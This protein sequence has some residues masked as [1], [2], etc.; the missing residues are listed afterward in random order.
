[1]QFFYLFSF[2]VA[3]SY[4]VALP[5]PAGLSEKYSSNVD[6][7][8]ASGLEARSYQPG[9]NS[10]KTSATLMSLKRRDDYEGSSEEDSGS[11]LS[12]LPD[13]TSNEP[14]SD[15]FT[16]DEIS[17][18]NL[19]STINR[20]EDSDVNTF[21][22]GELAGQRI[23][24]TVG[25][26]LARYLRRNAYVNVAL[27]Q[28]SHESVNDI[29]G[30]IRFNS[31]EGEHF[32]VEP[33]FTKKI[34]DLEDK[35]DEGVNAM[36]DAT[37]KIA[38]D[39]DSVIENVR[40]TRRSFKLTFKSRKELLRMLMSKLRLFEDGADLLGQLNDVTTSLDEFFAEQKKLYG[41]IIRRLRATYSHT[42]SSNP[43][44]P[45]VN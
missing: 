37:S 38:K 17:S 2:V 4:A 15:P 35:S 31:G 16:E 9:L 36:I 18:E 8:L 32:E 26:R 22:G 14:F 43:S 34:K 29:L 20:A 21:K 41:K 25:G 27:S 30:L 11:D 3:A 5:Q 42:D 1:M 44:K 45:R 23:G 7:T 24:G 6:A 10:Y 39:D 28:W 12:P 13:T 40:N 19:A 33:G